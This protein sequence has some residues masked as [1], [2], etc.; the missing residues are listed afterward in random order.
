MKK[1]LVLTDFT[2]NASHAEAAALRLSGKMGA[3][4]LLY[5]TLPYIPLI[6]NDGGGPYVTET[7]GMLF[8][9]SRERLQQEA[10]KLRETA[11]MTLDRTA[12]IQERNGEGNL[13][14]VI[15][16]LSEEE[17]IGMIIMG[18]R[19]GSALGHLLSG[20]DTAA[21]IRKATKPVLIIPMTTAWALPQKVVFATGFGPADPP[22]VD[23]LLEL[24][25]LLGFQLNV[26]HLSRPGEVITEIG[27]EIAFRKF[28][29]Q[30]GLSCT[31]VIGG[32]VHRGLQDYCRDHHTDVLA[33]THGHHA[34]LARLFGR[35]ESLAAVAGGQLAILVFP[36]DFN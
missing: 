13:S 29:D 27:P 6:P 2:D 34:L 31:R 36:P 7:A 24:S 33:L 15:H 11:V 3:D 1:L 20:S 26:V 5:H 19:S 23:Y 28:L 4:L 25:V 12:N 14:E 18:G 16:E 22:A 35:S 17:G 8:E 30:R 10:D 21:V 9:D 32:D